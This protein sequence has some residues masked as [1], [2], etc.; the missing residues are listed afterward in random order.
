MPL[1]AE[2]TASRRLSLYGRQYEKLNFRPALVTDEGNFR[3]NSFHKVHSRLDS[4]YREVLVDI[5]Q[6]LLPFGYSYLPIKDVRS[7]EAYYGLKGYRTTSSIFD[8]WDIMKMNIS[9]NI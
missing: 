3:L 5:N 6:K 4:H 2:S 1:G 7:V 8:Q 9:I